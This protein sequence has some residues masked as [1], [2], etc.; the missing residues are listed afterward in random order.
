[1]QLCSRSLCGLRAAKILIQPNVCH[2]VSFLNQLKSQAKALQSLHGQQ[3]LALKENARQTEL[4]CG[5]TLLYPQNLAHNLNAIEPA[6][7]RF[8]LDGKIVASNEVDGIPRPF[9][10]ALPVR[11]THA[12]LC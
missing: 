11:M 8:N 5:S 6:A 2:T 7:P 3:Q 1:M 10:G 9:H 4:A 12:R